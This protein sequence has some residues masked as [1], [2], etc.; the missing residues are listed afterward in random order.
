MGPN[1]STSF[2]TAKETIKKR[3]RQ[4]KELEKIVSND[5]IDKALISKLYKQVIQLNSKK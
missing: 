3:K 2:C 1:Q 4:C 5:G